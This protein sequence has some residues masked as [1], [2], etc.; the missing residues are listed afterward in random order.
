M[1]LVLLL[2]V[3]TTIVSGVT[4]TRNA[5]ELVDEPPRV[6]VV[7]SRARVAT[8]HARAR[9]RTPRTSSIACLMD[10]GN[11]VT[12]YDAGRFPGIRRRLTFQP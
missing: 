11:E 5:Y 6:M 12:V 7:A 8:L 10:E 4:M 9:M 2:M 3:L 1:L